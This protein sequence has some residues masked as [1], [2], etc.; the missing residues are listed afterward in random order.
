MKT[1]VKNYI[2]KGKKIESL[3]IIKIH[4]K[5]EDLVRFS[6]KFNDEDYVTIEV[7]K[8]KNPDKFGHEYTAYVNRLEEAAEEKPADKQQ[9][10]KKKRSKSKKVSDADP[11]GDF[12]F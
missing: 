5:I 11:A 10:L 1:F 8:L 4:L 3:E 6:H 9:T 7:A 12:P 2:G